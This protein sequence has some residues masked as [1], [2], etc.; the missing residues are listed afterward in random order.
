[1][2]L[3]DNYGKQGHID[4]LSGIPPLPEVVIENLVYDLEDARRLKKWVLGKNKPAELAKLFPA[5]HWSE[6]NYLPEDAHPKSFRSIYAMNTN[7]WAAHT[8]AEGRAL[9]KS[10]GVVGVLS[11]DQDAAH[12]WFSKR[13]PDKGVASRVCYYLKPNAL[14]RNRCNCSAAVNGEM[15]EGEAQLKACQ[16]EEALVTQL[17]KEGKMGDWLYELDVQ[18]EVQRIKQQLGYPE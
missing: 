6:L 11:L 10:S 8:S 15:A 1:M 4:Y 13:D 5:G 14:V 3:D 9:M 2:Q 7:V 12:E 18:K 16:E 17:V